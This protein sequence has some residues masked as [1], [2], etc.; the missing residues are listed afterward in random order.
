MLSNDTGHYRL[1]GRVMTAVP[2]AKARVAHSAAPTSFDGRAVQTHGVVHPAASEPSVI[3]RYAI[4]QAHANE[5]PSTAAD[6]RPRPAIPAPL[7]AIATMPPARPPA[8][9][10]ADRAA[11]DASVGNGPP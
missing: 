9:A 7:R 11:T 6:S 2:V 8:A 1:P 5:P 10:P 3:S 4:G